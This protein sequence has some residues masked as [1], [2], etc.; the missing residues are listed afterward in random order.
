MGICVT[1]VLSLYYYQINYYL[2]VQPQK[3]GVPLNNIATR[4]IGGFIALIEEFNINLRDK[5]R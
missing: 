2:L 3:K 4:V 5:I 1:K